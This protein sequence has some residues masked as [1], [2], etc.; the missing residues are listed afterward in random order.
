MPLQSYRYSSSY[1]HVVQIISVPHPPTTLLVFSVLHKC[2]LTT[3]TTTTNM[4]KYK[5]RRTACPGQHF[6]TYDKSP[7]A[8]TSTPFAIAGLGQSKIIICRIGQW[9]QFLGTRF[10][11]YKK[12]LCENLFLT[13]T[14]FP[15]Q[16]YKTLCGGRS[17]FTFWHLQ[18]DFNIVQ[19]LILFL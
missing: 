2:I 8:S 4:K 13:P 15:Y 14:P 7:T 18:T 1:R 17:L 9:T 16:D 11:W 10:S 3:T 5:N 12:N 6:G 19:P